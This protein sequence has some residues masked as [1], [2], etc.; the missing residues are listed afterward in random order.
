MLAMVKR[1][2]IKENV[3]IE[4]LRLLPYSLFLTYDLSYLK[5]T[6]LPR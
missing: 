3:N 4:L 6:F 5:T 1:T 2:D